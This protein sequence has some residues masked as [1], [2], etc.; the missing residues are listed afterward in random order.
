[1][2]PILETARLRLRAACAADLD[3]QCAMLGDPQVM[4]FVGG[5][6]LSR[7]ETWRK[8]LCAPGLWALIG[9]GYWTL[10]DKASGAFLGQVGFADFKRGMTPSIEGIPEMGW[11]L[12][13]HAQ[14]RGFATEA[15]LGALRLG[16]RRRTAAAR[17]R[18][19]HRRG[20]PRLDPRR[21]KSGLR[22][23][24]EATYK[25]APILLFRRLSP[26]RR[27]M[28]ARRS[29]S[30]MSCSFLSSAPCSGGIALVGVLGLQ[31][32][33]RHVLVQEQLQP[34]EQLAGR[35]LLLQPGTS[36]TW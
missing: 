19:D 31:H 33:E 27:A 20:Q 12:A 30:M 32:F 3:A 36:R 22:S 14:G 16:R 35:R 34:V 8:L 4:R 13:P 7:E 1:V 17:D 11:M 24:R 29:N 23:A 10:E 28:K 15:I 18:R 5:Q 2:V 26:P 21:R 9:Y 6:A 25:R